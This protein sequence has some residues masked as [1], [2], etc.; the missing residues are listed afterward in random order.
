MA[1][2]MTDDAAPN[3]PMDVAALEAENASLRDRML[4]A[5]ADAENTRRRA[6]RTAEGVR[7]YA[8]S[9]FARELL[10]VADNL[11]RSIAAAERRSAEQSEDDALVEG[12]RATL[13]MLEHTLDRFG[14]R[15]MQ[16]L[17]TRFDPALHEAIMEV[18]DRSQP[19]GTV[20][21]VDEDGY[22]IHDRLLRPA[23]VAVT[24]SQSNGSQSNGS[25][26][27]DAPA[28]R[29]EPQ[30]RSAARPK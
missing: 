21:R 10:A 18:D 25:P 4:R 22:T 14:V 13:R 15:R 16:A 5:L 1:Q 27:S 17:G 19:P 26:Q 2:S 20:A 23:R 9:D 29:G 24:K 3:E 12:V 8:I 7:Q 28:P 30:P 11:R 6:E